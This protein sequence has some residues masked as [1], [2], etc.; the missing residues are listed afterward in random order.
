MRQV[1]RIRQK[2][3]GKWVTSGAAGKH[4]G[5]SSRKKETVLESEE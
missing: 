2:P 5:E 4:L 3:I 1:L